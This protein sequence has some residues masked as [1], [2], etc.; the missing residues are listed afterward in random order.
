LIKSGIKKEC[1]NDLSA[2]ERIIIISLFLALTIVLY[3]RK[4][5]KLLFTKIKVKIPHSEIIEVIKKTAEELEWKITKNKKSLVEAYR[6]G[7]AGWR[8][9]ITIISNEHEIL[10][11]SICD[12]KNMSSVIAL[13]FDENKN[14][15]KSFTHNIKVLIHKDDEQIIE[16]S[17]WT[18]GKIA[19]RLFAY[20]FCIFLIPSGVY[21]ILH[22]VNYKSA[23]AG[24]GAIV[25]GITYLHSDLKLIFS[26]NHR[27]NTDRNLDNFN[28]K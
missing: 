22:P 24:I 10:F 7:V 20:P 23:W 1:V 17:E 9:M 16:K 28:S 14:N 12:P 6:Y 13:G 11:N 2:F 18:F 25:V 4:R 21:M 26:K 27:T 3:L 8:E 15:L 19:F 5:N